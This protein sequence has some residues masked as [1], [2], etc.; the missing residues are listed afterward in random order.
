MNKKVLFQQISHLDGERTT[1]QGS[2]QFRHD[3]AI[4]EILHFERERPTVVHH[5]V[6]E[7]S[8]ESKRCRNLTILVDAH[9]KVIEIL[10]DVRDIQQQA[11]VASLNPKEILPM[12]F[13]ATI[14]QK[15]RN[16]GDTFVIGRI[17]HI[18]FR[19][20]SSHVAEVLVSAVCISI[21]P[22][23]D[24]AFHIDLNAISAHLAEVGIVIE[25]RNHIGRIA[26][27]ENGDRVSPG[28]CSSLV[29]VADG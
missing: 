17:L 29:R 19:H 3:I 27:H 9:L 16:V 15:I 1:R 13:H 28:S 25:G 18:R 21:E 8:I 26:N 2:I 5:T 22:G 11:S 6:F 23:Q 10:M 20:P 14:A 7:T 24:V 12:A 4:S